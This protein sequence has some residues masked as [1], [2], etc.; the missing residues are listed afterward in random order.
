MR[1]IFEKTAEREIPTEARHPARYATDLR[2]ELG[3]RNVVH[4]RKHDFLHEVTLGG[5]PAVL[6]RQ[7]EQGRHG[8]FH[9]AAYS[10][11]KSTPA[12]KRRMRKV[13]TT[14]P[15]V[16]LSHDTGRCELDSCNSSDALL[17]SIFC[18]PQSLQPASRLR[19]LLNLES[20]AEPA[21]GYHPHIP[22]KNGCADSTEIDLRLGNLLV[23][24][25]LTEYGFQ[26]APW[27]LAERYR[28][29][30]DVFELEELPRSGKSLFSYQ[31]VRGVL[32]AH[33]E[34]D[35]RYSVLC[36]ARRPDL[37]AAWY[38][39]LQCVRYPALRCRLMLVTWQEI[40]AA[41]TTPLQR[42]LD[43]KYGIR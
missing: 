14:A 5:T 40:A 26:T 12:W 19:A 35:A 4:A 11:I 9:W 7:D 30:E 28:D 29:L 16:L 20:D 36:D 38:R 41:C 10:R 33:A 27:R 18:H 43:E 8:N 25:K 37:I 31:L 1:Y 42:W 21:F 22:L 23:E 13:H 2:R 34:Q 6:Y 17:M 24:A 39:I 15:K 32:A 3:E